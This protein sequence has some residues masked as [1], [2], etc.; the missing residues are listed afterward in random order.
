MEKKCT[1]KED[2]RAKL[3]LFFFEAVARVSKYGT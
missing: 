3:N 2:A 1:K